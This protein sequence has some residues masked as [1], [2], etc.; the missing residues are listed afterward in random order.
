MLAETTMEPSFYAGFTGIAWAVEHLMPASQE[1]DDDLNASIDEALEAGLRSSDGAEWLRSA[2][3]VAGLAGFGVYALERM[4]RPGAAR[5]LES[6]VARV[7]ELS[8]RVPDGIT[9]WTAPEQLPRESRLRTPEGCYN[10]GVAH[11]IPGVIGFLGQVCSAGVA[12]CQ[13]RELLDGAVRWLLARRSRRG[14]AAFPTWIAPT[15]NPRA[16]RVSWCYGNPGIALAL[17]VAARAVGERRWEVEAL[18]LALESAAQGIGESS[19]IEACLCHGSA[20]NGHL[21]NRLFQETGDP[22]F[23]DAAVA[24]FERT[25]ELRKPGSGLAGFESQVPGEDGKTV[26]RGVPGFLNGVSGIGLAL[27]AA[28]TAVEPAWDR[29]LLCSA[30]SP[31]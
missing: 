25:L 17:L 26:W 4:P 22:R 15:G 10:L 16:R 9:W 8:E 30:R 3:L 12:T 19:V 5:I 27:L 20:G 14:E 1:S 24:W 18:D 21:F 23:R 11:G 6:I 13:A 2:E 28:T 29:A 31:D 7:A